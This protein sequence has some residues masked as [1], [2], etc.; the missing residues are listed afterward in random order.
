MNSAGLYFHVPFCQKKCPYCNFYSI[1]AE[2]AQLETYTEAVCRNLYFYAA[3]DRKIDTI[4][5]G[6][7]TPSLLSSTQ[8]ERILITAAECFSLAENTEITLEANP[9][10][11][12][13]K[14]LCQLRK[15]G[16]NRLSLGIQSLDDKQL[17]CLG[18]LHTAQEA[19]ETVRDAAKAGFENISCDLMLALP[20]QTSEKLAQTIQQLTTLPITHVSAYLLKIESGTPFA[21]QHMSEFCPDEDTAAD[22]YLQAVEMLIQAGFLQYEIS[23]FA[24]PGFESRHNC[25]YWNCEPYLGIGPSAHSCWN[26]IRFS[27]PSSVQHF[28]SAPVQQTEIEDDSPCTTEE[29]IMLG[30]RLTKGIP[31]AWLTGKKALVE[32]LCKA[33]F[34]RNNEERIAFTPHG[35]LVSNTILAELL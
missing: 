11:V 23:N 9:A 27:V 19:I 4:Y 13:K 24:K 15:I 8:I 22:F 20:E 16:M 30:M 1:P 2:P 34:L 35:F 7:G 3:S 33:G 32:Q 28:L 31:A 18:R 12:T 21:L 25:K 5:F 10:T 29:R 26:G 14:Y 17:R 6:G